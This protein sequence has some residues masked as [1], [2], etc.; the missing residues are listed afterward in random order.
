MFKEKQAALDIFLTPPDDWNG[1]HPEK[2]SYF[3]M[4]RQN[5]ML[6]EQFAFLKN[7]RDMC[8]AARERSSQLLLNLSSTPVI[9]SKGPNSSMLEFEKLYP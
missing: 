9:I 7:D 2:R 1:Q 5:E 4:I 8:G 6:N 3:Q